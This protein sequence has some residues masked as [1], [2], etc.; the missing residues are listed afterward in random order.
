MAKR[1]T[2]RAQD[3]P[4]SIQLNFAVAKDLHDDLVD[5]SGDRKKRREDPYS[6]SGIAR[7]AITEWLERRKYRKK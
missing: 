6:I 5:A 3:L 7:E 4:E 2:A 1:E